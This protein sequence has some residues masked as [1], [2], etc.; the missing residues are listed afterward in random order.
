MFE[1]TA[2]FMHVKMRDDP[3]NKYWIIP[4]VGDEL[5]TIMKKLIQIGNDRTS[6][7][8]NGVCTHFKNSEYRL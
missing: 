2:F 4:D 5:K 8:M 3:R 7:F 6:L 1:C